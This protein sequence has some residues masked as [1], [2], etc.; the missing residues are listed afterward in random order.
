MTKIRNS[1]KSKEHSQLD[2]LNEKLQLNSQ[3]PL[4]MDEFRSMLRFRKAYEIELNRS[5][6]SQF[7]FRVLAVVLLVAALVLWTVFFSGII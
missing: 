5:K 2:K 6:K 4:S 7:H 3:P 1:A